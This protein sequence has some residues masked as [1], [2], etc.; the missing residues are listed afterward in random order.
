MW[1]PDID[2]TVLV[3]EANMLLSKKN[4]SVEEKE[5]LCSIFSTLYPNEFDYELMVKKH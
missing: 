1:H 2:S 4:L 5:R 3:K